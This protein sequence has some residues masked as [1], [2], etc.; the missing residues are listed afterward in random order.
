MSWQLREVQSLK[1]EIVQGITSIVGHRCAGTDVLDDI[2][3]V[4]N[5]AS[6]LVV[7]LSL[8]NEDVDEDDND[9]DDDDGH[10][11]KS[12]KMF[13]VKNHEQ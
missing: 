13:N 2:E 11:N 12:V 10:Y 3:A 7:I 4:N 8:D 9:D 6:P 5:Q 1:S